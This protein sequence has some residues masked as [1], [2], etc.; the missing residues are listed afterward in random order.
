MTFAHRISHKEAQLW[1]LNQTSE[2]DTTSA[3]SYNF[4]KLGLWIN[5]FTFWSN[6][7]HLEFIQQINLNVDTMTCVY[8]DSLQYSL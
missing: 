1:S 6:V 7:A 8:D 4:Q 5:I 3:L 2:A